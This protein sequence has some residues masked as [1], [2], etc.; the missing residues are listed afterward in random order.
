MTNKRTRSAPQTLPSLSVCEIPREERAV[1][2]H[3]CGASMI[4]G[5]RDTAAERNRCVVCRI[6]GSRPTL[7]R[8]QQ[9]VL[10]IRMQAVTDARD[11]RVIA[12]SRPWVRIPPDST[13]LMDRNAR[14]DGPVREL[15]AVNARVPQLCR[16]SAP[17]RSALFHRTDE[18]PLIRSGD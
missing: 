4:N 18:R 10:E 15:A 8:S 13:S 11:S 9:Y 2:W 5:A 12:E 3:G 17:A 7:Q 1:S 14:A 16:G 6:A